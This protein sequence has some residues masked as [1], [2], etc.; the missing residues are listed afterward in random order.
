MRVY[1]DC[2]RWLLWKELKC[3]MRRKQMIPSMLVFSML[4]LMLF[5]FS[6]SQDGKFPAAPAAGI[7]WVTISF[8]GILGLNRSLALEQEQGLMDGLLLAPVDRSVFYF[9]KVLANWSALLL[10]SLGFIPLVSLFLGSISLTADLVLVILL[11]TLGIAVTGSLLA[12]MA[13]Q[14]NSRDSMLSILLFPVLLPLL[15]AAMKASSAIFMQSQAAA[16]LPWIQLMLVY[17]SVF[18]AIGLMTYPAL[19]E[20]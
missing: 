10:L 6:F 4:M 3:E 20:E 11:G 13:M 16:F 9:S 18:F 1:L 15:L 19:L 2:L 7:I 14:S 17:D 5:H 8:A 12:G